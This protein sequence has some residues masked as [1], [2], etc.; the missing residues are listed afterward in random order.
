M[1]N[2]SFNGSF[3]QQTGVNGSPYGLQTPSSRAM[4]AG[5]P[6]AVHRAQSA[7]NLTKYAASS[8]NG[9]L[10]DFTSRQTQKDTEAASRRMQEI[11][12][13]LR[14]LKQQQLQQQQKLAQ[15][16]GKVYAGTLQEK[17]N[18]FLSLSGA[19]T[20][21]DD[22][23]STADDTY[24]GKQ[25]ENKIRSAKT[26][27]S[28]GQA[29]LTAK[30]KVQQLKA[31]LNTGGGDAEELHLALVHAK[32]MEAVA[33]KKKH[34]LELEEMAKTVMER[35]EQKNRMEEAAEGMH[36][37]LTQLTEEEIAAKEDEIF[38]ERLA[39]LDQL[40]EQA[41]EGV[42]SED[43]QEQ[44]MK[45]LAEFGEEMFE[46]LEETMALVE[47]MEIIDPHMDEQELKELKRKH[48]NQEEKAM[49]KA[50]MDYLKEMIKRELMK[51][52]RVPGTG[53]GS[54]S[55]NGQLGGSP[56]VP[57]SGLDASGT[58]PAAG[59]TAPLVS[60]HM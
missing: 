37:A 3:L 29:V 18:D 14:D 7:A 21:D 55:V 38:E 35:D 28:A 59:M 53:G 56:A 6:G 51:A 25:V 30:R 1:A 2:I 46:Q 20:D 60:F 27:V 11:R 26:S 23:M 34:H 24:N 15:G 17:M 49:V 44:M 33:R 47:S 32:R 22:Q 52:G 54:S 16:G 13:M 57:F 41:A 9:V 48:R 45:E 58:A 36:S 43:F 40:K 39:L 12:D 19:P 5:M 4:Q 50:D 31:K 42:V 10:S 8:G